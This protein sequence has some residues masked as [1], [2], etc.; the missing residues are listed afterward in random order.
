MR[1]A[2]FGIVFAAAC[3]A[4]LRWPMV[5]LLAY[6]V[7]YLVAPSR[8]WW[9]EPLIEMG[10]RFSMFLVLA[11][12]A[13]VV[14]QWGKIRP[15]IAG[16]IPHSQEVLVGLFVL[17]VV[18]SRVWGAPLDLTARNLTGTSVTPE[19]KL[20]KVAFFVFLMTTLVVRYSHVRAVFWLLVLVGGL[21][22]GWDGYTARESRFVHGRLDNLGGADFAESSAVGA[23]LTFVSVVTGVLFLT[24]RRW[25][26]KALCLVA[27]VLTVNAI[28]LTQTRAAFL[29]LLA[30]GLA[31]PVF[32]MRGQRMRIL[33]YLALGAAGTL[34][35]TNDQFVSRVESITAQEQQRDAAAVSRLEVWEA[36]LQMWKDNPMGV[37]AGSFY[38]CVGVYDPRYVGRDC[39]NTY[40]RCLAELGVLGGG[41]FLAVVVNAFLTLR[42][43]ARAA[44][45]TSIES[46]VRWDCFGLKVAFVGYLFAGMFM[47]L[48]YIE[49]M[50]WFL[51]LPVCLHR[52]ALNARAEEAPVGGV[53]EQRPPAPSR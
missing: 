38:T 50:W 39:H 42:R 43:A 5:G 10:A 2:L 47:G 30:A 9:G 35:L 37:G 41:L 19:E 36:G 24:S 21:Y 22:L 6:M 18:L 8:Q 45:G 1:I 17:V 32:A 26:Q 40:I 20:P 27:G 28:I 15:Q 49:E 53:S 23:H 11:T 13:G 46:D 4:A 31:A 7:D 52:S 48:T 44:V 25:W 12:A 34:A 3:L 33:C 29:A 51:C 14:L 16:G